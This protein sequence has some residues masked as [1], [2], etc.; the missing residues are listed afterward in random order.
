VIE[1][2]YVSGLVMFAEFLFVQG[3]Y[4]VLLSLFAELWG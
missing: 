2:G 3:D 1:V 4:A